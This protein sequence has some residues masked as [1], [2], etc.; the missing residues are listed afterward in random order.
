MKNVS[1][2]RQE[3][4][5]RPMPRLVSEEPPDFSLVMG[6]PIFQL[7]R[8]SH[9][10]GDHMELLVRRILVITLIAW[11]PVSYTHLTLPTIYSV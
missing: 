2:V 10:A 3:L 4:Q 9:L 1:E 6:G 5:D 7:F 11:A 8:R